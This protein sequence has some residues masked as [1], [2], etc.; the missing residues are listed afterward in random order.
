MNLA[1]THARY[2]N[3]PRWMRWEAERR[4]MRRMI[5]SQAM[6]REHLAKAQELAEEEGVDVL[7]VVG[8]RGVNYHDE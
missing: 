8:P 6:H 2:A 3:A 7:A 1:R 5:D 4:A